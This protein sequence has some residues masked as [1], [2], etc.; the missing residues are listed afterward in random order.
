[1]T[2]LT[3]AETA[4]QLRKVQDLSAVTLQHASASSLDIILADPE[5]YQ[6]RYEKFL[7]YFVSQHSDTLTV[8]TDFDL[9]WKK[10]VAKANLSRR[11]PHATRTFLNNTLPPHP[12][13]KQETVVYLRDTAENDTTESLFLSLREN[14]RFA[15]P[16]TIVAIL[17][18]HH[19]SPQ[20][21]DM[22]YCHFFASTIWQDK[23]GKLWVLDVYCADGEKFFYI[24]S[25]GASDELEWGSPRKLA[26]VAK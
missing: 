2:R 3:S 26:V 1:M 11:C 12:S 9:A 13:G 20:C 16:L 18:Q 14:E 24:R 17:E 15:H 7:Q 25:A 8:T 21:D 23:H 6:D 5:A 10:A 19:N 4:E 22:P